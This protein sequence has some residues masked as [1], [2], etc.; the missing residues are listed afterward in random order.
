MMC[1]SKNV[2][3][4]NRFVDEGR[5]CSIR[6]SQHIHYNNKCLFVCKSSAILWNIECCP[7]FVGMTQCIAVVR[8]IEHMPHFDF[9]F[10]VEIDASLLAVFSPTSPVLPRVSFYFPRNIICGRV[11][12]LHPF[13][14]VLLLH[15]RQLVASHST[16]PKLLQPTIHCSSLSI[17]GL[18]LWRIA[19]KRGRIFGKVLVAIRIVYCFMRIRI[20]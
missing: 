20:C 9:A 17:L 3:N 6:L 4:M 1:L 18:C 7:S 13:F 15:H 12:A 11:T 5:R 19:S 10:C 8:N 14:E 2:W 16:S